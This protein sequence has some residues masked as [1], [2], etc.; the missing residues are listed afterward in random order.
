MKLIAIIFCFKNGDDYE[1]IYEPVA[2]PGMYY[3]SVLKN[4]NYMLSFNCF[5]NAN[6]N[7]AR[8]LLKQAI[9]KSKKTDLK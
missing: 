3:V 2:I 8:G 5:T 4:K 6:K 1:V 9:E 7:H